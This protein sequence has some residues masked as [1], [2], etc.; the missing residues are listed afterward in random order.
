MLFLSILQALDIKPEL[1]N[2]IIWTLARDELRKMNSYTIPADKVA[3]VV[4]IIMI[5][6]AASAADCCY[7]ICRLSVQL[8]YSDP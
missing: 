5:T 1:K 3:C 6:L 2:D 7:C 4:S 8:C